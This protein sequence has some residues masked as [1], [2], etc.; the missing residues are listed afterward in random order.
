MEWL[1]RTRPGPGPSLASGFGLAI[2][3]LLAVGCGNKAGVPSQT[4]GGGGGG[5]GGLGDGTGGLGTG[6]A[7]TGGSL[8]V[9]TG[10]LAQGA[11]GLGTGGVETGGSLGVGTG[12]LGTGGSLGLDAGGLGTGGVAQGTGGGVGGST[13]EVAGGASG[14]LGTA[15]DAGEDGITCSLGADPADCRLCQSDIP[16]SCERPCPKVDCSIFPPPEECEAVC[17]GAKCCECRHLMGNEYSW[18]Q[19]Q[20]S[21]ECGTECTD[22]VARWNTLFSDPSLTACTADA[23]CTV[24]GG[25]GSCACV[26]TIAGCGKAA[27]LAAYQASGAAE[28]DFTFHQ[29]CKD[30]A[31]ACD[32]GLPSTGCRSGQCVITGY[33]GCGIGIDAGRPSG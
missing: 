5:S 13:A 19:R 30:A 7:E 6:G 25:G 15:L 16:A 27:N 22:L 23:D 3:S 31:R 28:I 2:C 1:R 32:C 26:S 29:D 18:Q 12:G 8:G 17:A 11:G 4:A 21:I 33:F 24:V 9:G 20:Q 10:G 14:G